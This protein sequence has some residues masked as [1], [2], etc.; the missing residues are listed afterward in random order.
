MQAGGE[1]TD[2][3]L[4]LT[5]TDAVAA[6]CGDVHL[7]VTGNLAV[8]LG[9]CGR[10]ASAGVRFGHR[11]CTMAYS[12][13]CSR[14]AY[15]GVALDGSVMHTRSA[16]NLAFYG[17]PLSAKDLLM[18]GSADAPPA[19]RT[20]YTALDSMVR[21]PKVGTPAHCAAVWT[22]VREGPHALALLRAHEA[23]CC[24]K[25][26]SQGHGRAQ[27]SDRGSACRSTRLGSVRSTRR[28]GRRARLASWPTWSRRCARPFPERT[29]C[30]SFAD[31]QS[32]FLG[33]MP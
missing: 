26:H 6:F 16:A 10:D 4:V 5:T 20:L 12:Y 31:K 21:L 29:V 3:L 19:A 1:L 30:P 27:R 28:R 17:R 24:F 13:S 2:L 25:C 7:G 8:T 9:P 32:C 33:G 22:R 14:G 15:A 23:G 18:G 11:G